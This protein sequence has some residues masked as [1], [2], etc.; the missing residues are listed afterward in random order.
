MFGSGFIISDRAAQLR[1]EAEALAEVTPT[2]RS[3][4]E[5]ARLLKWELSE[6]ERELIEKLGTPELE[7]INGDPIRVGDTVRTK[8]HTGG[9][10]PPST[11]TGRG[12]GRNPL[13]RT[14]AASN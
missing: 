6:R 2:Y 7:D 11:F 3:Q 13:R 5:G 12:S 10:L 9:F 14:L 8:Q 4:R 1:R